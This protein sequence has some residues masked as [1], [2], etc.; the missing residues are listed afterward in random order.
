MR[1]I[2]KWG[3]IYNQMI[4]KEEPDVLN[5]NFQAKMF[6]E[7]SINEGRDLQP[8]EETLHSNEQTVENTNSPNK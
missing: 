8:K 4:A 1:P 3:E 2:Q 7:T 5:N 6:S